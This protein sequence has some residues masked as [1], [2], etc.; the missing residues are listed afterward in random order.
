MGC[1]TEILKEERTTKE[2]HDCLKAGINGTSY[3][4]A[5]FH[6]EGVIFTCH[7]KLKS[8]SK[9]ILKLN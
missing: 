2:E 9:S 8:Q 7:F 3:E 4:K 1:E 5:R 6:E